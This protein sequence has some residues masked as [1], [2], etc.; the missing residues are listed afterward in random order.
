M[1]NATVL[2][3]DGSPAVRAAYTAWDHNPC[4]LENGNAVVRAIN[5]LVATYRAQLPS[6]KY[7]VLLGTTQVEPSWRQQDLSDN[8]PEVD[9]ASDLSFTTQGMTK[10]NEVYAT[11]AQNAIATDGAYGHFT[12]TNWLG[13]DIP[14][15]QIS[16]SR[17]VETP[18]D[19]NGQLQQFL[20]VNGTLSPTS[21]LTTGDSFFTDGA[22]AADA[23]LASQFGPG[24]SHSFLQPTFDNGTPPLVTGWTHDQLLSSFFNASPVPS[25]GAIWAHYSHWLA[26]PAFLPTAYSLPDFGSTADVNAGHPQNGRLLF[27]VGCH[28]GLNVPDT[29]LRPTDITTLDAD[30]QQRFRDWAQ[31]YGNARAAVYVANSGFGYGDTDTSDLSERLY[32]HLA[33]NL[34]SGGTI[35]EQWVRALHQYYSEPSNYDVIDEKVMIEANM[36]GLPFYGFSGTPHNPPPAVT[37]PAHSVQG[38]VDTA[39]LPAVNG[40]NIGQFDPLHPK[41]FGDSS[42]SRSD[43]STF[44]QGGVPWTMG[45]LSV[46]YRPQ[47]PTVSRDVTVPGT[48][49]HGAWVSSLTSHTLA[50]VTPYKPFPLVRS[51]DDKPVNDFPNI[52]FPATVATVNRDVVFGAQHDTLVVNL[53]RFFPNQTGDRTKGT[54]QVVDSVGLDL[55]YSTS[56]DYVPPQ[57]SQTGA[58]T[59]GGTTTAF[60]RVSDA[61]GLARVAVLYHDVGVGTWNILQLDHASGDLWT[62]TFNDSNPLQLDSEAEDLNGNVAYSFNKAVNFQSVPASSVPA[63]SILIDK[64]LPSVTFTLNQQVRTGFSCSSAAAITGCTG[65]SDGGTSSQSG[66]LLDTSTAGVHTFVVNATDLAGHTATASVTYTVLFAFGGFQSPVN[67]PPTLNTNKAG[68]TIPLIWSLFDAAGHA[69]ANL[70]ALQSISSKQIRCPNATTDPVNPPDLPIGTNGVAGITGS[71]FHFNWA[72]DKKWAGTCRRLYVHLSDGTTQYADFQFS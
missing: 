50:N 47:Q 1:Q 37:P 12:P 66:G 9:E 55:G 58:V 43:G 53:G 17:M 70:N 64:P 54:E 33:N 20:S 16:V 46:F 57:I 21:A 4:N 32:D 29:L 26:Q 41:L 69:Y 15:P 60:V 38:G 24:L 39:N 36:Y 5:D 71:S 49:A 10:G 67:N 7:I 51:A 52:Y 14:I 61:S 44:S 2:Q 27:T 34:N 8:A 31:A 59:N 42:P 63:P 3:V 56:S 35:G 13:H 25:I 23:A 18:E 30:T 28:G 6:L 22:K 45:T 19:I 62:K 40:F 68:S 48:V 11:A 72:T 65:A